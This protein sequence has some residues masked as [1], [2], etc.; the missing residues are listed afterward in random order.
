VQFK[1]PMHFR[2]DESVEEMIARVT[3]AIEQEAPRDASPGDGSPGDASP[4][5][6]SQQPE[7]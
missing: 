4:H 1:A 5:D 6:G 3:Q 7:I 2:P